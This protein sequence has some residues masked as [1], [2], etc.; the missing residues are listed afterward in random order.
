[1]VD[2][3]K[4]KTK[5]NLAKLYAGE[6][7]DGARYQFIAQQANT[8]KL[9]YLMDTMKILAKNEMAHAKIFYDLILEHGGES[10]DNIDITA[11]YPFPTYQLVPGLQLTAKAEA[12][13]SN[14]IYPTFAKTAKEEGYPD[15]AKAMLMVAEVENLHAK[16]L[17]E[18]FE[19]TKS[20]KLYKMASPSVWKC[21]KCGYEKE[22][23]EAWKT[24]PLC[25]Y[26]QGYVQ[27]HLEN[28]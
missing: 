23:K 5:S 8:D 25:H 19:K 18:L 27:L 22:G 15:V 24:C 11:G 28:K 3:N 9:S 6:C 16:I 20:K 4:S 7:Q 2:F 1:M 12:S 13:Q 14:T 17:T 26:D 10:L 21:S